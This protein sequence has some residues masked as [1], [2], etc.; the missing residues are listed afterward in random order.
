[1]C[2]CSPMTVSCA[3]LKAGSIV[4]PS[5]TCLHVIILVYRMCKAKLVLISS[6]CARCSFAYADKWWLTEH[7]Y[8]FSCFFLLGLMGFLFSNCVNIGVFVSR[9]IIT[10]DSKGKKKRIR[11]PLSVPHFVQTEK[12]PLKSTVVSR[13]AK[14]REPR[15][16]NRN[17]CA[18]EPT[19]RTVHCLPKRLSW[20]TFS[21]FFSI[22]NTWPLHRQVLGFSGNPGTCLLQPNQLFIGSVLS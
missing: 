16:Y 22:C 8:P 10:L 20:F 11:Q 19:Q 5:P 15:A 4:P 17:L 18:L 3:K 2:I 14:K 21:P 6:M 7:F 12:L 13:R 9:C 1:M